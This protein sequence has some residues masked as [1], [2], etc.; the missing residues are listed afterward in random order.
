MLANKLGRDLDDYASQGDQRQVVFDLVR[1]AE[2][3]GFVEELVAAAREDNPGNGKL[4]ALSVGS[5]VEERIFHVPFARNPFFTGRE[6]YLLKVEHD[7]TK[8]GIA[9]LT[10]LGGMGKSQAGVEYAYRTRGRYRVVFW[11]QGNSEAAL[12]TSYGELAKRLDPAM[13]DIANQDLVKQKVI[14]WLNK[15]TDWLLVFDNADTPSILSPFLPL[16]SRGHIIITSRA[17]VVQCLG[18]VR[19]LEL[20]EL[21]LQEACEFLYRRTGREPGTDGE[22]VDTLA[23]ELG[24]LPLALEQAAAYV[25]EKQAPFASYLASFRKQRLKLLNKQRP[26]AGEPVATTWAMNFKALAGTPAARDLLHLSAFLGPDNIPLELLR[27]GGPQLGQTLFRVLTQAGDD[28]LVLDEQL[29]EPLRRY[30]LIKRNLAIATYNVHRLV[31]EVVAESL[32]RRQQRLWSERAVRAVNAALPS[33]EYANWPECARLLAHAL[34]CAQWVTR[35][36]FDFGEAARLLDRTASYLME[37][38]QYVEA[39]PLF[40]RALVIRKSRYGPVHAYTAASIN[41]LALLY[42]YRERFADAESLY[43][44][45]LDIWETKEEVGPTHP[46]TA[47]SLTNLATLYRTANRFEEA[48]SLYRRALTIREQI[49]ANGPDTAESLD[50]LAL[51]YFVQ[52][53][54]AEGAPICCRALEIRRARIEPDHPEL[55]AS[56]HNMAIFLHCQDEFEAAERLYQEALAIRRKSLPPGHPATAKTIETYARLLRQRGREEEARRLEEDSFAYRAAGGR[57]R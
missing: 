15:E 50:Q 26:S 3:E 43:R 23:E 12:N 1:A 45:A 8:Q 20:E 34:V 55:G 25:V 4:A 56:C 9:A 35:W 46:Y 30:S 5:P 48:E 7:L 19:P 47:T 57:M 31:Q 36:K 51:L 16:Q 28:P 33:V 38:A 17:S 44:S 54:Y 37:R 49:D 32:S 41:N 21:S 13:Q 14:N 29:L 22:A 2:R 39:E 11:V 53:R 52:R 10:G 6:E 24:R 27:D 18:I 40:E 42:Q